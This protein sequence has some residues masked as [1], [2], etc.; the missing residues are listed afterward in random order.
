ADVGAPEGW[1]G[2]GGDPGDVAGVAAPSGAGVFPGP[3]DRVPPPEPGGSAP[4]EPA[5][6]LPCSTIHRSRRLRPSADGPRAGPGQAGGHPR[7][8]ENPARPWERRLAGP[9]RG[10]PAAPTSGIA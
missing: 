2:P 1:L 6:G 5:A 8:S 4:S 7:T 3:R 10:R 9:Y